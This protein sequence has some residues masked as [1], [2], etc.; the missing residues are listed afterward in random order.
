MKYFKLIR[1]LSLALI[2]GLSALSASTVFAAAGDTISNTATLTF[3]VA[4]VATVIESSE[5][6]NSTTG[7]GNGTSTDFVED[8]VINFTVAEVGGATNSLGVVPNATLRVQTFTVT[9]NGNSTQDFLLAALNQADGTNDP[10]GGVVDNF[11]VTMQVF[12]ET[13]NAGFDAT[14]DTDI[15]IDELAAGD[16]IT[17]YIVSTI[18]G[19]VVNGDL[20]VTTLVAQVAAGGAAGVQGAAIVVDDNAHFSPA[21]VFSN[22]ATDTSAA[23]TAAVG[24]VAI[25][26]DVTTM[27]TVFNDPAGA[28]ATDEDSTGAAQDVVQNGQHSDSDSYTVGAAV[29]TVSKTASLL[30]DPANGS[31]NPKAIPLAYMQYT[32]T[33]ANDAGAGASGDLTTLGDTLVSMDLDPD[34]IDGTALALAAPGAPES[35]AGDS[36]RVDTTGTGRTAAGISY[37]TGDDAADTDADGC[38]YN[39]GTGAITI[40]YATLMPVEGIVYTAGELKAGESV[41]IVF[42]AIIQ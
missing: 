34:L 33:V 32:I 37:C 5:A 11:D 26:D 38:A 25:A 19:T 20:A 10:F 6:G 27:Q 21:G 16:S 30:W 31:S 4:G 28:T 23:V 12:V 13:A 2:G 15:F 29:L 3:D 8:K 24:T 14:D 40:N 22:G 17:V 7:I 9:N 36:F 1:L 42:N 35:A 41:V 39:A 18:P